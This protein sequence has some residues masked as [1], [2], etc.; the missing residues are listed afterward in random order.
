[1]RTENHTSFVYQLL[2]LLLRYHRYLGL[3]HEQYFLLHT[4]IQYDDID[5]IEE[6]TGFT[7]QK[8]VQMMEEMIEQKII[9]Y[10]QN[11]GIDLEY[12]FSYLKVVEQQFMPFRELLIRDYQDQKNHPDKKHIGH[13]E[14]LPMKKGIAVRLADGKLLSLKRMQQ[15]SEELTHY[16][17]YATEKKQKSM[18]ARLEDTASFMKSEIKRA[19]Q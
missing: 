18:D 6:I 5:M 9:K 12:L 3:D 13:V 1:M 7:E 8:I 10:D 11:S 2:E 14:L 19:S 17:A 15:L 16:V 4:C